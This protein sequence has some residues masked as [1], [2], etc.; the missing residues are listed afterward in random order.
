MGAQISDLFSLFIQLAPLTQALILAALV[1]VVALLSL[2]IIASI[3]ALRLWRASRA[4]RRASKA[5]AE[6]IPATNFA[7]DGKP[8]DPLNLRV[9][10]TAD[11][12]SAAFVT[13]GWYRADEITLVTSLRI[14]VD[15]LLARKYSSAPVSDLYLYGRKQDFAFEKPGRSVRERDHVRF[16]KADQPARDG[17]PVWIGGATRDAKVELSKTNHLPTH[18]I[19]P[20]VDDERALITDDLIRTGWVVVERSVPAF[21]GPTRTQNAMGDH[22]QT[23]GMAIQL[24]LART[25]PVPL[26][27]QLIRQPGSKLVQTVTRGLRRNLPQQGRDLARQWQER[28]A[29]RG[30]KAPSEPRQPSGDS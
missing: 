30:G 27:P 11:Q 8:S 6:I 5:A 2:L 21:P 17:R 20:D 12:L 19:A 23:D 25:Q 29:Q 7:R 14:I 3:G 1:A 15:A 22:Y 24:T 26:L 28:R 9:I 13:A 10:G 18:G 4:G 16:W